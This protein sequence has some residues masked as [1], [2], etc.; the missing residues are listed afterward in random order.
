MLLSLFSLFLL[1]AMP[2]A[3][4]FKKDMGPLQSAVDGLMQ[5][6]GVQVLQKSR[7]AYI[8]GYGI[9][10]TLEV[11]FEPPYNPFTTLKSPAEVRSIVAQRRKDLQ[12]KLT[13][14]VKQ[15][16]ATT[17]S[18]GSTDSLVVVVHVLNTNRADVPNMP[19]QILCIVKRDASQT[20][21]FRELF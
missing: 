6:L 17:D 7:A 14:F 2:Q 20:P 8:E 16:V 3:N 9:I 18:I 4:V 1:T 15:R 5:S 11:A 12:E 21:M 13:A 10:V 19:I